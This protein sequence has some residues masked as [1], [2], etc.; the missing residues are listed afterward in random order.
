MPVPIVNVAMVVLRQCMNPF[1]R[2][3]TNKFFN[4][5][6]ELAQKTLGFKFFKNFGQFCYLG[7]MHMDRIAKGET[8]SEQARE[9][10]QNPHICFHKGIE[11]F[12]EIFFFY[13]ILLTIAWWEIKKFA[14]K[15]KANRMRVTNLEK[16]FE[17]MTAE[18]DRVTRVVHRN[19]VKL[20]D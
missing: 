20:D 17:F 11:W 15:A 16:N 1:N 10:G 14:D 13:G 18:V 2:A 3:L 8:P 6:G 19:Q 5:G 4:G 9:D 12:S 7:E